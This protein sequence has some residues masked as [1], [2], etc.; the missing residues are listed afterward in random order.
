[1]VE[2]G[3]QLLDLLVRFCLVLL[4]AGF[5][6]LLA[7]LAFPVLKNPANNHRAVALTADEFRYAFGNTMSEEES[8][9]AY[10]RY[11]V[12]APGRVL[13]Q[14]AF[15]SFNPHAPTKIDWRRDDRAPLLLIAG[16]EDHTVPASV[17]RA[18][19]EK[20]RRESGAVTDF[21]EFPGR[22]HFIIGQDG[23]EGVADFALD[24]ALQN[25]RTGAPA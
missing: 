20:Y 5:A 8:I 17:D 13:F 15:A 2:L 18:V 12:P 19:A 7:S 3:L 11:A 21:K 16:S 14:G 22:S 6:K 1:V 10:R 4:V 24:W 9:R 25:A 23:W